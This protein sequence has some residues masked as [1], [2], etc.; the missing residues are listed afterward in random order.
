[1]RQKEW[2]TAAHER[3]WESIMKLL[4]FN[5]AYFPKVW[6]MITLLGE[7]SSMLEWVKNKNIMKEAK[8]Y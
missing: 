3:G 5:R 6:S 2:R 7:E 8:L 4:Y 1:M